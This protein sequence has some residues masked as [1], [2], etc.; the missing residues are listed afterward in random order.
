MCGNLYLFKYVLN[1]FPYSKDNK[2]LDLFYIKYC[3]T[4]LE[5]FAAATAVSGP[6][7][8]NMQTKV[9]QSLIRLE[10]SLP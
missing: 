2:I 3:V 9:D 10:S 8:E 6:S 1:H 5:D 7:Q 4:D